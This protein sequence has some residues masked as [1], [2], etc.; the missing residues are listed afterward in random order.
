MKKE[1]YLIEVDVY[2]RVEG[3]SETLP[4]WK[5]SKSKLLNVHE[6]EVNI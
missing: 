1:R 4:N 2:L 3:E 6:F 5:T